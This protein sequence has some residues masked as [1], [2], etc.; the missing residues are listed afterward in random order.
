M[1]PWRRRVGDGLW[2]SSGGT[3]SQT[4]PGPFT[5]TLIW[6]H[7]SV[8]SVMLWKLDLGGLDRLVSSLGG[9]ECIPTVYGSLTGICTFHEIESFLCYYSSLCCY[10]GNTQTRMPV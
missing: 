2:Y 10:V 7:F 4:E 1:K 3:V 5:A 6:T 9:P 8:E